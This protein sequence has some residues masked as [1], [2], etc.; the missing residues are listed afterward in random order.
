MLLLSLNQTGH[1]T[2]L[3]LQLLCLLLHPV[4]GRP[5]F[6]EDEADVEE[7]HEP[8]TREQCLLTYEL[9]SFSRHPK[10]ENDE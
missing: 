2:M 8:R 6:N 3:V 4:S 1:R 7:D 10:S 5:S 9:G